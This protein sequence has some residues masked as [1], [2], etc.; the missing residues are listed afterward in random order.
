MTGASRMPPTSGEKNAHSHFLI[1][2][3]SPFGFHSIVFLN[4]S[5]GQL[6]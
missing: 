5:L 1:P 2:F 3:F 4:S 6:F